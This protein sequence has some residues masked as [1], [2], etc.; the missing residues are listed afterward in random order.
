MPAPA[1]RFRVNPGVA[2][3]F[4]ALLFLGVSLFRDY[5]ISWDEIPT[6]EFGQ[7]YVAQH[8]PDIYALEALRAE[9][10]SAWERHGPVFEIVLANI[11]RVAALTD[12]RSVF[13]VRHF[14]TFLVFMLGVALFYAFCRRRFSTGL[15][16]F[17]AGM[18]VLTPLFFAHA[19]YNTKDV[20]FLT[21]FVATMFTLCVWLER[22][23]WPIVIGHAVVT[24]MLVST[25]VLG[26]LAIGFTVVLTLL[27]HRDRA[28]RI[29]LAAYAV[30]IALLL[31]VFWPVLRIDYWG[32][33]SQAVLNASSNTLSPR[34]V[35]FWG[36]SI[37]P[38]QLPW[39]YIPSWMLVTI[40]IPYLVLFAAG[41]A[42]V[43]R[44]TITG[45]RDVLQAPRQDVVVVC[46]LAAPVL[47]TIV[48]HPILYDGWRHLY[49]VY[50]ALLYLGVC[51]AEAAWIWGRR[52]TADWPERRRTVV[53][54]AAVALCLAPS[55]NFMATSHPFEHLYF[56]KIAG[57]DLATARSRFD[58]DYWGLSYRPMLERL[59]RMDSSAVIKVRVEN[60]PGV[61]NSLMLVPSDRRRLQ[62]VQS[63]EEADYF[64]TN[65]R[66]PDDPTPATGELFSL[67]LG[68]ATIASLFKVPKP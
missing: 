5:G 39:H 7:M 54:V 50:P 60:Y 66:Y 19:F 46:W 12:I 36:E 21:L 3:F 41:V 35:M 2:L 68:T 33:L 48:L 49:F 42:V 29:R 34:S 45:W 17:A 40:P 47:M 44:R 15:S 11:E 58:F 37:S 13:F 23:S 52:W 59:V 61:A 43:A 28:A 26:L 16:L 53:A 8:I 51:G 62:Y 30:L 6:R 56:N 18:L 9:K 24:S 55:V 25:R 65:F 22:P 4:T 32:V 1:T 31:P 64:I 27:R 14:A 57:A 10:G 38:K 67:R 63:I 20:P